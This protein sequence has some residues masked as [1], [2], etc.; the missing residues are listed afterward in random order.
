MSYQERC[1]ILIKNPVLVARHFQ[2]RVEVSFKVIVLN[3][4][5]GKTRYH[6]VQ[7]EFPVSGSSHIHSFVWILNAT[8]LSKDSKEE[9]VKWVDSII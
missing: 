3:G 6:A 5:F 7:L 1:N 4:P 8:K 9:Y 2:Y